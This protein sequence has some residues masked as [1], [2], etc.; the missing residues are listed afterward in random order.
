MHRGGETTMRTAGQPAGR[1][2]GW[3][4]VRHG[5]RRRIKPAAGILKQARSRA[6]R[7]G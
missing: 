1:Q 7:A 4:H 6:G 3:Y 5:K 2:R